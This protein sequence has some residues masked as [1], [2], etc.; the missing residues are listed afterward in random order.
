MNN[1]NLNRRG[2][3]SVLAMLFLILFGIL[4]LGFYGSVTTSVQVAGNEQ[5]SNKARLAA[6]SGVQFMR[7]HLA[8]VSVPSTSTTVLNDL[9]VDLKAALENTSNLGGTTYHVGMTNNIIY[10]PAEAGSYIPLDT[11]EKT[12]FTATIKE[13][14]G[15]VV[16]MV[17]GQSGQ[18]STKNFKSVSM[19]F[20][21]V[22]VPYNTFDYAVASKG[23]VKMMKGSLTGV[24]GVSSDDIATMMSSKASGVA[25]NV[26]GGTIGGDL[27]VL[28]DSLAS[29]TGGSVGGTNNISSIINSHVHEVPAPA[30][31]TFDTSVFAT[32]ATTTYSS[33]STLSNVRIPRNTN[34][35]FTGGATIQGIVY[36]ESPNNIEFRG[37]VKLNGFIVFENT[38]TSA[39]NVIDMKGNFTWGT[40]PSDPAYDSLR[41]T[42]GIAVLGPTASMTMSG[43]TDSTVRGNVILGSFINAGSADM[44]IDQ[45]TL[46]TLDE[47]ATASATFN[48][49]TV[50]FKA[51]GKYNQPSQGVTYAQKYTPVAGSFQELD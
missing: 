47:G 18:T 29:V 3:T 11:T 39:Q 30:F 38:N 2:I 40:L 19:E 1:R 37:N 22:T 51:T 42:T 26:S 4:A 17:A 13:W 43:S 50:K 8:H 34:P 15:G 14:N 31:P 27:N 20:S 36:V 33:G 25:I 7:Y 45:G 28:D 16:C 23:Q 24:A 48:G 46:M 12:G 49:K 10:I 32:Y 21:R 35:K 6:E 41:S 44:T 5:R 9:Y